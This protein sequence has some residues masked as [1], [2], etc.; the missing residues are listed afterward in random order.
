MAKVVVVTE[1]DGGRR[2]PEVMVRVDGHWLV[3]GHTGEVWKV[4]YEQLL[5]GPHMER[6]LRADLD[7]VCRFLSREK[8]Q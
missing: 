7:R 8:H 6:L 3:D 2:F 5:R 4:D 1:H